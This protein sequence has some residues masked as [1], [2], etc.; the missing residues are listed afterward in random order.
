M[1]FKLEKKYILR[2]ITAFLVVAGGIFLYYLIFH[3][4][5]IKSGMGYL[6]SICIPIVN[7]LVIAYIMTPTLNYIEKKIIIRI[8]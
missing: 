3:G 5:N 8:A 6:Y 2:G 4:S 1:K 7:G